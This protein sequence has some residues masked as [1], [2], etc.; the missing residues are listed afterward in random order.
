MNTLPA[1]GSDRGLFRRI[2]TLGARRPRRL[3]SIGRRSGS[4]L[5]LPTATASSTFLSGSQLCD[6]AADHQLD[7]L[8]NTYRID[9]YKMCLATLCRRH[10]LKFVVIDCATTTPL[11]LLKKPSTLDRAHEEQDF[12]RLDI[13]SSRDHIDSD[14]NTGIMTVSGGNQFFWFDA[15]GLIGNILR[16]F[17]ATRKFCT[18]D[19]DN[20]VCVIVIFGKD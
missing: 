17:I 8:T 11:H 16:E 3:T 13:R 12:Q 14:G 20:L 1:D 9:N 19:L 10:R 18:Y 2:G 7:L 15:R 4:R 6:Q 5:H